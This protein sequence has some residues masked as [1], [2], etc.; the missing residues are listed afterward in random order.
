MILVDKPG[1]R[2]LSDKS[3]IV[4]W[5]VLALPTCRN[6]GTTTAEYSLEFLALVTSTKQHET[7]I[8]F[9]LQFGARYL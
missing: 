9:F 2:E 7:A 5:V 1:G 6:T 3:E 4:C 8:D